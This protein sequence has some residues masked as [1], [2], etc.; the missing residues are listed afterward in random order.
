MV[1]HYFNPVSLDGW[2]PHSGTLRTL[3]EWMT[4]KIHTQPW[5]IIKAVA[6]LHH[7]QTVFL[8]ISK[9]SRFID[10]CAETASTCH[11]YLLSLPAQAFVRLPPPGAFPGTLALAHCVPHSD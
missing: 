1:N 2:Y 5:D 11:S 10:L 9:M 8:P 6:N 4:P 7:Q 3:A